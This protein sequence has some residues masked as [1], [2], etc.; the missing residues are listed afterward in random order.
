MLGDTLERK[1]H[2]FALLIAFLHLPTDCKPYDG[3]LEVMC[4]KTFGFSTNFI[5]SKH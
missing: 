4:E 3:A 1:E 5:D 2:V